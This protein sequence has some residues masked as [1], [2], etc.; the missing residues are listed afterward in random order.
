M[1]QKYEKCTG[2][3]MHVSLAEQAAEESQEDGAIEDIS[4]PNLGPSVEELFEEGITRLHHRETWKLWRWP[5]SDNVFYSPDEFK[6]ALGLILPLSDSTTRP[7][8]D[9][10]CLGVQ[11]FLCLSGPEGCC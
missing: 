11:S 9:V 8:D 10:R 5:Q 3:R 7:A 1:S 4:P 2:V 6:C